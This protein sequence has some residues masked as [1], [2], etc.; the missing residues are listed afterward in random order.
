MIAFLITYAPSVSANDMVNNKAYGSVS[1]QIIQEASGG[2]NNTINIGSII[3]KSAKNISV[4]AHVDGDVIVKT[5]KRSS[6]QL[7]IGSYGS[8][9]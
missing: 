1:G 7:N 9:R 8:K 4:E 6:T 3:K 2:S 5:S